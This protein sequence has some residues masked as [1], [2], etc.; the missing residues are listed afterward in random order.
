MFLERSRLPSLVKH[1]HYLWVT[2]DFLH[3]H[4]PLL[5]RPCPR[6][7]RVGIIFQKPVVKIS[8]KNDLR[9]GKSGQ[10]VAC[11]VSMKLWFGF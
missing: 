10:G 6:G 5:N 3:K 8:G 4:V 7:A 9:D 1:L 2:V 11:L